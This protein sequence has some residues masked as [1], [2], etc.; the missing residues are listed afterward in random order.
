MPYDWNKKI[1]KFSAIIASLFL[2]ALLFYFIP[3]S[4]S[5][6]EQDT[7]IQEINPERLKP[8]EESV[9]NNNIIQNNSF[10][11]DNE[12][13]INTMIAL[14]LAVQFFLNCKKR[15]SSEIDAIKQYSGTTNKN[16]L[17]LS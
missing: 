14:I 12:N 7:T 16:N 8:L 17:I 4:V 10:K 15:C 9:F 1:K 3:N 11:K 6:S 5:I 2:L 13:K